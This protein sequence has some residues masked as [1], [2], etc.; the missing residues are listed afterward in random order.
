MKIENTSKSTSNRVRKKG[1]TSF[2]HLTYKDLGKFVGAE[3][4]VPVHKSWLE[5]LGFDIY[6][7]D[8]IEKYTQKKL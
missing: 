8:Q 4:L 5:Q 3:T 1:S 7:Q 6:T 2:T